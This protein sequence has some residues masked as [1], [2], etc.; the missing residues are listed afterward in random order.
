MPSAI[1]TEDQA[2][3]KQREQTRVRVARLRDKR[4]KQTA[5]ADALTAV[6]TA[7]NAPKPSRGRSKAALLAAS[8]ANAGVTVDRVVKKKAEKLEATKLKLV[9][10]E[11]VEVPDHASQQRACEQLTKDLQ[12]AGEL[13]DDRAGVAAA[14]IVVSVVNFTNGAVEPLVPRVIDAPA[15]SATPARSARLT[16]GSARNEALQKSREPYEL[17]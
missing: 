8:L 4:R 11:M 10:N 13:P 3:L 17:P 15:V 1:Q 6:T 16:Y 12:L 14:P 9:G 7:E 5:L 2:K